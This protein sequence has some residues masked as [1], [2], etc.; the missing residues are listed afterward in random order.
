MEARF[1][2]Q[3][4]IIALRIRKGLGAVALPIIQPV[5]TKRAA[6]DLSV[7]LH[8]E[9]DREVSLLALLVVQSQIIG[10]GLL[11]LE[12]VCD[13]LSR[14]LEGSVVDGVEGLGLHLIGIQIHVQLT[15]S[16]D[17]GGVPL[18]HGLRLNLYE[19][20]AL[21]LLR[22]GV[23][24][25]G[26]LAVQIDVPQEHGALDHGDL[27]LVLPLGKLDGQGLG[28]AVAGVG[29]V[30]V[31]PL[32][33]LVRHGHDLVAVPVKGG[34]PRIPPGRLELKVAQLVELVLAVDLHGQL[35]GKHAAP[36]V[37]IVQ[38][39]VVARG[40]GSVHGH[41]AAV[42][43]LQ[44]HRLPAAPPKAVFVR[45]KLRT[46]QAPEMLRRRDADLLALIVRAVL[47]LADHGIVPVVHVVG[48]V[49]RDVIGCRLPIDHAVRQGLVSRP[50]FGTDAEASGRHDPCHGPG[51][52]SAECPV[53]AERFSSLENLASMECPASVPSLSW[54]HTSTFFPAAVPFSG[55][56]F[57]LKLLSTALC[58]R[59]PRPRSPCRR[60][61]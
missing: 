51:Q 48:K 40:L 33:Y 52:H 24:R 61:P 41:D 54:I 4:Q 8:I 28:M 17:G 36:R 12:F 35:Q 50:F 60:G 53:S 26:G 27:Q 44:L 29:D 34:R 32:H 47:A 56:L 39:D 38:A 59:S 49:V 20:R 14:V 6:G 22:A 11:H 58:S 7:H 31:L 3:A 55:R 42:M 2:I 5:V 1:Q 30:F 18:G 25:D 21:G 10:S 16:T 13:F 23:L 19:V 15:G 9:K 45:N 57:M 46:A 37:Q 43:D